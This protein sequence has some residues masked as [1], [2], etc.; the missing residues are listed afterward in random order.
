MRQLRRQAG[1]EGISITNF[2]DRHCAQWFMHGWTEFISPSN[3]CGGETAEEVNTAVLAW[4][5]RNRSRDDYLLH[6]NY[7]DPHRVYRVDPSWADRLEGTPCPDW[8]DEQAIQRIAEYTGPFTARQQFKDGRSPVPLM[9]DEVTNR[10]QHELMVTGYDASIAYTDHHLQQVLDAL[11]EQG[12]LDETVIII[13]GDHGDAFGE[14][15]IYSDHVCADECIHRI[16]LIVRWPGVTTPGS[17]SD[18]LLYHTDFAPTLCE[19]LDAPI[20]AQWDGR[21]FAPA[22]RGE[23]F[24]GRDHLV[25][26]HGLYAT[27]RAVRTPQHLLIRTYDRWEYEH[28]RPVELY[29]MTADPYQTRD[30]ASIEPDTVARLDHLLQDWLHDQLTAPGAIPDPLQALIHEQLHQGRADRFRRC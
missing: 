24:A 14:H 20:P 13:T 18:A 23:P 25:W 30:L 10:E 2:A 27:Q 6:I 28:L 11:D 1:L 15:G 8:P 21:S 22:L 12:V 17:A 4:L 5:D 16:P 3:K 26:T 19:M 7:W 29:D 9:P